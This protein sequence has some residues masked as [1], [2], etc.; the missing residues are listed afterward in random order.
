MDPSLRDGMYSRSEVTRCI[1]MG[2]LCVQEEVDARPTMSA[3]GLMLSSNSVA[4]PVPKNLAFY[5]HTSRAEDY[6]SG[7]WDPST[8]NSKMSPLSA[9]N[10]SITDVGPR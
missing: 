5:S 1:H 10:L 3:I 4:L 2:L 8:T 7:M 6:S 9:N